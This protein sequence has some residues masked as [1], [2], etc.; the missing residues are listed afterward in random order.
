M[1]ENIEFEMVANEDYC[2]YLEWVDRSGE[3]IVNDPNATAQMDVR[4]PNSGTLLMRFAPNADPLEFASAAVLGTSGVV[5]LSA[6]RL[7]TASKEPGTYDCDLVVEF[8][9]ADDL[10]FTDG[11]RKRVMKGKF[12]VVPMT[13]QPI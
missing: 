4:D 3:F 8:T 10:V 11:Q 7:V 5:R 9:D 12:T 1:A 2:C 6:P 13:T